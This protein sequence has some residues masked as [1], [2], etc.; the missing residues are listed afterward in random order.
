MPKRCSGENSK[1]VAARERKNEKATS[2]KLAKQKALEDEYWKDD[3]KSLAKKQ[4]KKDE[5]ER[6]KMEALERKKERQ[7]LAELEEKSTLSTLSK[8]N[9]V[10]VT[11]AKIREEAEKR[12]QAAKNAGKKTE[13]ETHLSKPLDENVNRLTVDGAEARSVEEAISV[14]SL[15][16][17]PVALDK[18]PEKRMKAAYE[19][20]ESE[21][22]P[23]LKMENSNMRLSQL[24]QM[25]RKEWQ[26]NPN[27][28]LNKQ[29]AAM[30]K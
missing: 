2:E 18:H 26:K 27:N 23:Q 5:I 30:Y 8:A 24:K 17:E 29:L 7:N 6:K 15:S 28:P 16:N 10:K 14:L 3:N 11:Q 21:R 25:L 12:Q 9:P 22:L 19:E 4:A 20:F 13:I 1:A